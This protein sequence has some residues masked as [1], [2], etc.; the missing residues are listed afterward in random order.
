MKKKT[1]I[2]PNPRLKIWLNWL[3]S[4]KSSK[5]QQPKGC[6]CRRKP[7]DS[8][9][10]ANSRQTASNYNK[11]RILAG[12]LSDPL[13]LLTYVNQVLNVLALLATEA[14]LVAM[15]VLTEVLT[16][17]KAHMAL[18]VPAMVM[19]LCIRKELSLLNLN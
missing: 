16:A 5:K 18:S 10:P 6:S 9:W 3:N 8:E 4:I 13:T 15:V 2:L 11:V 12:L 14:A 1:F 7:Q 19:D 17:G